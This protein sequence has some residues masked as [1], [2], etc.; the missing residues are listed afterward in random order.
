VV[1][2][3]AADFRWARQR[4]ASVKAAGGILDLV[5]PLRVGGTG[6]P[7]FCAHPVVG[8]SWCY[9][10]LPP[11]VDPAHPLYGLQAR[12][13][14]RP[15]PLP[16]SMAEAATDFADQLRLVQPTGPYHVLGW[17]LGGNFAVAIA[18]ELEARGHEVGLVTI[19]DADPEI[20]AALTAD[21]EQAWLLYNFV[22]AEF[23]YEPALSAGVPEPAARAHALEVI[24][25]RP[26]LGLAEWP[27]RR[28]LAL[29]RVIR[30]NVALARSH[31]PGRLRAPVLFVAATATAPT[32]AEKLAHWQPFLT[33]PTEVCEV[34]CQHQHL[35]LPDHLAR[36]G[37][38]MNDALRAP[39]GVSTI[40]S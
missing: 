34:D 30:N 3:A 37:G 13:L 23:G 32:T 17:S 19:L 2:P 29:F 38:A 18:E 28:I 7:V 8:L 25:G 35:L 22:L 14:R 12:G 5:L 15:E 6:V 20:S 31:R 36:I 10:A 33:G 24:R 16:V 4:R 11:H 26:G 9:L 27:E 39:I 40:V 21:D 1:L